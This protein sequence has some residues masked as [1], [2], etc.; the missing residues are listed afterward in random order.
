MLPCGDSVKIGL[1]F[2]SAIIIFWMVFSFANHLPFLIKKTSSL[3]VL[4][5]TAIIF[6]VFPVANSI[7]YKEHIKEYLSSYPTDGTVTV[8]ITYDIERVGIQGSIGNEWHYTHLLNGKEFHNGE[9][10]TL[11]ANT[12]FNITSLF[13]EEDASIDDIGETISPEYRF[14]SDWNNNK[15]RVISQKVHIVENGGKRYYGATAD[16]MVTYT[17]TRVVPSSMGFWKMLLYSNE[18]ANSNK[19]VFLI[20]GQI[21]N[22]IIIIFVLIYGKKKEKTIENLNEKRTNINTI[23]S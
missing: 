1:L 2:I 3:L 22:I 10:L 17:I 9:T 4:F 21:F 15:T 13:I 16:Y 19:N 20:G 14:S 18:R 8:A 11:D 23:N 6:L 12:T 7:I 5:I